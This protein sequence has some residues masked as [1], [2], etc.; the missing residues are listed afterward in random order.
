MVEGEH[1]VGLAPAEV[2]LELDDRVAPAG[3]DADLQGRLGALPPHVTSLFIEAESEQLHLHLLGFRCLGR[4]DRGQQPVRRVQGAVGVI[5]RKASLVRPIVPG[6]AQFRH[7]SAL[8]VTQSG[9]EDRVPG[10]PHEAE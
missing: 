6:R 3:S 1:G 4:R 5:G 10:I 2:G 7:V 9:P 8:G